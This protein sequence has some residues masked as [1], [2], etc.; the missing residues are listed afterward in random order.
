[1]GAGLLAKGPL[2]LKT[3]VGDRNILQKI[4]GHRPKAALA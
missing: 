1:V 4:D 3:L 2:S